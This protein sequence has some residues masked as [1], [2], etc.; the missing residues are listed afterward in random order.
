MNNVTNPSS[1]EALKES[2]L[3]AL[4]YMCQD[5]MAPSVEAKANQILTAIVFGMRKDEPSL[6]VRLAATNAMLN[7]L[8]LTKQNFQNQ[9]HNV[10]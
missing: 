6:H 10:F 2:S 4:G 7:A 9:V 1:T 3:E 5:I 8:E